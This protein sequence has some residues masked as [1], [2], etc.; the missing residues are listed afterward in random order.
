MIVQ[1][2]KAII[3]FLL[4]VSVQISHFNNFSSLP[5]FL[6]HGNIDRP[7]FPYPIKYTVVI[8]STCLF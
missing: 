2:T 4:L 1:N 3:M 6:K 8:L 7:K 5:A